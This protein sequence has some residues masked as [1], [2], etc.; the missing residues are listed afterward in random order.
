MGRSSSWLFALVIAVR[1]DMKYFGLL[2]LLPCLAACGCHGKPVKVE[3]KAEIICP[4][5]IK[6]GNVIKVDTRT[7][8]YVERVSN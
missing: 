1:P 8:E 4:A 5:F 7:G 3:T 6:V 2:I